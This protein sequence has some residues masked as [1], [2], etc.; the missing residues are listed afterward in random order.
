MPT[1]K[2]RRAPPAQ[3]FE[4]YVFNRITGPTVKLFPIASSAMWGFSDG[5]GSGNVDEDV[6]ETTE[7]GF[8]L[9]FNEKTYD[10]F[11]VHTNGFMIL[12]EKSDVG[13]FSVSDYISVTSPTTLND[14]IRSR[15]TTGG[16]MLCPWF[17]DLRT[18]YDNVSQLAY[19]TPK[20]KQNIQRGISL[21]PT[22]LDPTRSGIK[23]KKTTSPSGVKCLIVRWRS[24]SSYTS[25]PESIITFEVIIY[26]NGKIEF[27]Y[28]TRKT[29]TPYGCN[30]VTDGATIGIFVND[31]INSDLTYW[32][33]RDLSVGLGHPGDSTRSTSKFGGA[34]YD[35]AY[36]DSNLFYPSVPYN[37]T[38]YPSNVDVTAPSG[39]LGRISNWP[40][41]EL[42]CC[43]ITFSPPV[44]RM[45]ILPRKEVHVGDTRASYPVIIRTGDASNNRVSFDMF[46]D[47]R[48]IAY[49]GSSIVNLP[50]TLPRGYS[51]NV[52]GAI[53]RQGIYGDMEITASISKTAAEQFL[54]FIPV[55]YVSP[56]CDHNRPEQGMASQYYMTGSP[57]SL[58]GESL[59]YP[60]RSKTQIKFDLP[61]NH[62]LQMLET[63]SAIYYYNN[64]IKGMFI[65]QVGGAPSD[66]ADPRDAL[67]SSYGEFWPEDSRCFG[68]IGNV[69]ASGSIDISFPA[70][71]S[72]P[73]FGRDS[74]DWVDVESPIDTLSKTYLKNP[75]INPDYNASDDELITIPINQPFVVEKAVFN[76][77][78]KMGPGWF[79]DKTTSCTPLGATSGAG[80][81]TDRGVVSN[82]FDFAGPAITLSLFNQIKNGELVHRDLILTGTVIP[83]GDSYGSVTVRQSWLK[84]GGSP[85]PIWTFEPEGFVKYN[86]SPSVVVK[87][88]S[89]G[90]YTG[91]LSIPTEAGI[92][93]GVTLRQLLRMTTYAPAL[94]LPVATA[95]AQATI[96]YMTRPTISV[97]EN[98]VNDGGKGYVIS[99]NVKSVNP[100][101]RDSR[102]NNV[103]GRSIFG[104]EFTTF[105]SLDQMTV[106]NPLF[107]S[108]SFSDFPTSLSDYLDIN[109]NSE[110]QAYIQY[111]VPIEQNS[112]SPYLL[113]P[114]DKLIFALSKN[115]PAM[116]T[117]GIQAVTRASVDVFR[118]GLR[119]DVWINTGSISV[120]LY[121]SLLREGKEFHDTMNQNLASNQIHEALGSEP[122]TDQFQ[123]EYQDSFYGSYTDSMVTGSMFPRTQNKIFYHVTQ[124]FGFSVT[125]VS[126]VY[127]KVQEKISIGTTRG[128]IASNLFARD[129]LFDETTSS[130]TELASVGNKSKILQPAY[131]RSGRQTYVRISSDHERF[132]DSM[133]PNLFDCLKIDGQYVHAVTNPNRIFFP[134]SPP[135][136][137][138]FDREKQYGMIEINSVP[139]VD[140]ADFRRMNSSVWTKSFPFEHR[141]S[142]V[143]RNKEFA[144]NRITQ[145]VTTTLLDSTS[146]FQRK[147]ERLLVCQRNS[148]LT[149]NVMCDV[150]YT[151]VV[152]GCYVTSSMGQDD[153]LKFFYGFGDG[154]ENNEV[155]PNLGPGGISF[156]EVKEWIP[157]IWASGA[158]FSRMRFKIGPVISG[159]KYGIYN[160]LPSYSTMVFRR[161]RY[162]NFR[163]MLEQRLDTKYFL[164][165]EIDDTIGSSPVKVLFVKQPETTS[166]IDS[167]YNVQNLNNSDWPLFLSAS[168][169]S[170]DSSN[171][172]FEATSSLPYFDGLSKNR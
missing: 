142:N 25:L 91:S 132:F 143:N 48:S 29:L 164:L 163:D 151:R 131:E 141:Y 80:S 18:A 33:F 32:R 109:N 10:R 64:K 76:I 11:V 21:P 89:A 153:M 3:V 137:G 51:F 47:R 121:G 102:G 39:L 40:G 99:S 69:V 44:N 4:N 54:S 28:D 84:S 62:P 117:N 52:P 112:K 2:E 81:P 94:S 105:Q 119:H 45:R 123:V 147:V 110:F 107:V 15:F 113:M 169:A 61:L 100:F 58:F 72:D 152:N 126:E 23:Y 145:Y 161:D 87:Q 134:D 22:P 59:R 156:R 111:A 86:S 98:V 103:S 146:A 172:S 139:L 122:V 140:N 162:G 17:G 37:V 75:Q 49:G 31:T 127:S 144:A 73:N 130:I 8:D 158:N 34:V 93:N 148:D 149:F 85:Y 20:Q 167:I 41:Q 88:S 38:M 13:V 108:S 63:G 160:G 120:T 165:G 83:E 104:K 70:L 68:P 77:P 66:I 92:S 171:L 1:A 133:V 166:S 154:K 19:T 106:K 14:Y 79:N 155:N 30:A 16:V 57:A 42:F 26:E 9:R 168:P 55:D 35:S 96:D 90:T 43:G 97:Y 7:L 12:R 27:R 135:F 71:S 136:I 128:S 150:D 50:T 118:Q 78:V 36:G 95:R 82:V 60:L 5:F 157:P 6:S 116:H 67:G 114:G 125:P 24:F 65:P 170:T 101:G 46:D 138:A 56:F 74:E 53:E 124:S 129:S 159:W 115:R